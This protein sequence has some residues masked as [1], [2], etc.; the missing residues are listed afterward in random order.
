MATMRPYGNSAAATLL[1]YLPHCRAS[2]WH[3]AFVHRLCPKRVLYKSFNIMG[4]SG[5]VP[6]VIHMRN[7]WT[8]STIETLL[9]I[10]LVQVLAGAGASASPLG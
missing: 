7:P 6:G 1:N 3:R 5:R 2:H 9:F 10:G 4:N 8:L